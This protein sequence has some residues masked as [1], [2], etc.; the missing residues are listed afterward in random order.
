MSRSRFPWGAFLV[1]ATATA[2][3]APTALPLSPGLAAAARASGAATVTNPAEYDDNGNGIVCVKTVPAS[4]KASPRAGERTIARDDDGAGGCPGGFEAV[5]LVQ[6]RT[7]ASGSSHACALDGAGAAWCWGSSANGALGVPGVTQSLTPVQVQGAPPLVSLVA[8]NNFTCGLDEARAAWCWGWNIGGQ[9]GAGDPLLP[10]SDAP[11]PVAGGIAFAALDAGERHACG[12]DDAGQ[13]FCWGSNNNGALGVVGPDAFA[14]VAGAGALRFR[15]V[16]AGLIATCGIATDDQTWCWG[17]DVWNQ[18]GNGVVA[19]GPTPSPV[20]S[21][22]LFESIGFGAVGGCGLDDAGAAWCW[23]T[24]PLN[25]GWLG[26][27]T[28]AGSS[29]PVPVSGGHVFRAIHSAD[30]NNILWYQCGIDDANAARC[31]G[32]NFYGQLGTAAS[33]AACPEAGPGGPHPCSEVPVAVEG[34][35]AWAEIDAGLGFVCGRTTANALYCW[36]RN[37]T[38]TLGDGTLTSRHLPGP[39]AFGAPLLAAASIHGDPA[40]AGGAA[41]A[42]ILKD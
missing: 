28:F 9:L 11:V 27:G 21:P 37:E 10:F 35:H 6:P 15:S 22:P 13:L 41:D 19:S 38:G 32:S 31:W 2:C 34:G 1:L 42:R 25:Y 17:S 24:F 30:A 36:G 33:M 20:A 7:V 39:V 4:G 23:S 26:N 8:G 29:V 40:S 3:D 16:D 18:G 5:S 14:P 12:M